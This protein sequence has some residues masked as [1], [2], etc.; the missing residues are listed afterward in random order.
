MFKG[1]KY[2]FSLSTSVVY[3]ELVQLV[4]QLNNM[5]TVLLCRQYNYAKGYSEFY[6][7]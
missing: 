3:F 2:I 6:C 1:K 5:R 7:P 4:L